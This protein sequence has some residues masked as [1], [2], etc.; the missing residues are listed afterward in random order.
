MVRYCKVM[1]TLLGRDLPIAD[2]TENELEPRRLTL[3]PDAKRSWVGFHDHIER[4]CADDGALKPIRGFAC[5]AAE[6]AARLATVLALVDNPLT[7]EVEL[8]FVNA[9]VELAQFYT[10]E[11]L[12]LFNASNQNPDLMLAEELLDWA[13]RKGYGKLSLP[14]IYQR[15]PNQIRDKD[16]AERIVKLLFEHGRLMPIEGG[17]KIDGTFRRKAWRVV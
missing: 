10:N 9:G 4:L 16:T 6:H 13:V 7:T 8:E 2:E 3:S 1:E 14:T 11:A 5:K 12:R 17:A 15:G